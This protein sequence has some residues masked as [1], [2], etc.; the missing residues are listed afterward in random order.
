MT[1]DK[2]FY[3][4]L[5]ICDKKLVISKVKEKKKGFSVYLYLKITVLNMKNKITLFILAITIALTFT[6]CNGDN[7]IEGEKTA[8]P[9]TVLNVTVD[10]APKAIASLSPA[11][12][13]IL[14]ELGYQD[15]IVGYSKDCT[16]EGI[17]DDQRIGTGLEPDFEKIGTLT[18]APEIIF[19]TVPLTKV[20]FEKVSSVGIKVIVMP[21][22]KS[23]DELKSRFVEIITAMEGEIAADTTGAEISAK[24]QKNI[25]HIVS[26]LPAEKPSFLYVS[27]LDPII[28]TPDTFESSLL[29]VLG[30]NLAEGYTKYEVT[31]EQVTTLNPDIIFFSSALNEEHIKES[32]LFKNS[33]AVKEGKLFVVNNA[34]ITLQSGDIADILIEIAGM[35]YPDIDFTIPQEIS[36]PSSDESK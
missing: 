26:K 21:V 19:T 18:V 34:D 13:Q 31:A 15:K 8:Y 22:V 16:V 3:I 5:S 28:A 29:S 24:I 36:E 11:I 10:Q 12:T 2:L 27:A 25:D 14:V 20:Q 17:T 23:I 35:V 1:I 32:S 7:T 30:N 4:L 6:A 33:N 9:A